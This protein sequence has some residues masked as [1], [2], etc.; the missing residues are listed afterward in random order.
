[1][2][3]SLVAVV[4]GSVAEMFSSGGGGGDGGE[5]TRLPN[6]SECVGHRLGVIVLAAAFPVHG[7]NTGTQRAPPP[8]HSPG[9]RRTA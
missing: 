9:T 1:M 7:A 3:R 4:P 8:H 5:Y 6:L 2:D